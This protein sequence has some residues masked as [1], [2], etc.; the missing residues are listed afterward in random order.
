MKCRRNI[1]EQLQPHWLYLLL[2]TNY[3]WNRI[4]DSQ[5]K[6]ILANS[7]FL[8]CNSKSQSPASLLPRLLLDMLTRKQW[9]TLLSQEERAPGQIF[10]CTHRGSH[11]WM[12][13]KAR[14]WPSS[15]AAS[16]SYDQW[17]LYFLPGLKLTNPLA[18]PELLFFFSVQSVLIS[19]TWY[20]LELKCPSGATDPHL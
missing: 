9:T 14:W 11:S 12:S 3:F 1:L 15:W 17:R 6:W 2:I 13:I 19:V 7:R 16:L 10:S 4:S 20:S 8:L 5:T 18:F